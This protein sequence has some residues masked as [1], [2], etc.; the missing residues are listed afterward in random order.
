M[1]P[2]TVSFDQ[3][4]KKHNLPVPRTIPKTVK[5]V[6]RV[7]INP[8]NFTLPKIVVSTAHQQSFNRR[9]KHFEQIPW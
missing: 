2:K 9:P 7:K 3:F 8:E 5:N 1:P 4:Q 6:P